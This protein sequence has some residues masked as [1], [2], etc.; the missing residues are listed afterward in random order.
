MFNL[1]LYNFNTMGGNSAFGT[2]LEH[3]NLDNDCRSINQCRIVWF[4]IPQKLFQRFYINIMYK[5]CISI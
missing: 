3:H 5:I 4:S 2:I 1:I